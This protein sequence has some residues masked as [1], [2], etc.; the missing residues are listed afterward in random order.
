M[1]ENG[2][3]L[4][5]KEIKEKQILLER[6]ERAIK[7]SGKENVKIIDISK[8]EMVELLNHTAGDEEFYDSDFEIVWCGFRCKLFYGA[9]NHNA[10]VETI[11]AAIE[12]E[13]E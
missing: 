11:E 12:E 13:S 3:D 9:E 8:K 4:L 5:R 1:Y 10:I 7:K 6:I 2:A